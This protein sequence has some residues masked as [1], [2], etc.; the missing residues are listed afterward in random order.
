MRIDWA[1]G[2]LETF[3][4]VC[5][6]L[7]LGPTLKMLKV[8]VMIMNFGLCGLSPFWKKIME[9]SFSRD[10]LKILLDVPSSG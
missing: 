8:F 7:D 9:T 10:W 5:E 1:L 3:G 6:K 4:K 2:V